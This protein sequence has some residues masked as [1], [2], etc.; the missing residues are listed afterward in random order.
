MSETSQTVCEYRGER[1]DGWGHQGNGGAEEVFCRNKCDN[2]IGA[3]QRLDT[4][5]PGQGRKGHS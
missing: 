1:G 2:D 3:P 4:M 5:V